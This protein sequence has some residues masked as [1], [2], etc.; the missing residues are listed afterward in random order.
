M[1]QRQH[2]ELVTSVLKLYGCIRCPGEESSSL[3]NLL[4]RWQLIVLTKGLRASR[5]PQIKEDL[6]LIED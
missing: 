4:L 6:C 1:D 5:L 3:I 2:G